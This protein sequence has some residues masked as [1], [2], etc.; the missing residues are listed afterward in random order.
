MLILLLTVAMEEMIA[1]I[2]ASP[3]CLILGTNFSTQHFPCELSKVQTHL[4]SVNY[5]LGGAKNL[6]VCVGW[7]VK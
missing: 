1:A 5:I 6:T 4:H 2:G 7:R 3:G